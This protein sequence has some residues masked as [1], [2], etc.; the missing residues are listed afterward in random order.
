MKHRYYGGI[1]LIMFL[2][3]I[4]AIFYKDHKHKKTSNDGLYYT[5]YGGVYCGR[6]EMEPCGITLKQCS[7]DKVYYCLTDVST[8]DSDI[9]EKK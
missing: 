6:I 1:F 3:T 7:T 2:I 5:K 9:K 8:P 4:S